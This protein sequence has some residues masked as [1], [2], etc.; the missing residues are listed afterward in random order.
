MA[1]V[2]EI[3]PCGRPGLVHFT[4][5]LPWLLM[6]QQHKGEG[7]SRCDIDLFWTEYSFVCTETNKI[8]GVLFKN[9][10]NMSLEGDTYIFMNFL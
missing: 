5:S 4:L 1:L 2:V 6:T 3:F 10:S 7:I 9:I 8:W